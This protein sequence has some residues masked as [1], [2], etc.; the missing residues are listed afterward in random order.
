MVAFRDP[1]LHSCEPSTCADQYVQP[2]GDWPMGRET[3]WLGKVCGL[4]GRDWRCG[5]RCELFDRYSRVASWLN[6]KL[7]HQTRRRSFS[8]GVRRIVRISRSSVCLWPEVSSRI[9]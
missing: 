4:L 7:Y 5:S 3:L 9:A 1:D 6:R 2:L 8:G